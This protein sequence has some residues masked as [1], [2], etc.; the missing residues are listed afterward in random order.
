MGDHGLHTCKLNRVQGLVHRGWN[1]KLVELQKQEVALIDAI[2]RRR[3]AQRSEILR[4]EMKIAAGGDFELVTNFVLQFVAKFTHMREVKMVLAVGV[5]RR[6]DLR[7]SIGN[8]RL[9]HRHRFFHSGRAIIETRQNVTV[10]IDHLEYPSPSATTHP[11][12]ATRRA[13]PG[14]PRKPGAC[15][16]A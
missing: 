8:R 16:A 10:Q 4:V 12:P 5:R 7:N 9:R 1:R 11:A 13:K 3:L 6:D 2:V 14:F 15:F